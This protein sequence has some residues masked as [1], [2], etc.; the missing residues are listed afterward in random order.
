MKKL[1]LIALAVC[2][3]VSLCACGQ[4]GE[5]SLLYLYLD[6][7]LSEHEAKSLGSQINHIEGVYSSTYISGQEALD[8][9]LEAHESELNI[10]L[11][12]ISMRN[13]FFVIVDT[14]DLDGVIQQ[15]EAI[16][17][18]DQVVSDVQTGIAQVIRS[19]IESLLNI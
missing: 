2:L 18:V 7:N 6:G 17:G 12:D 16:E 13:S 19:W 9:F 14:A 3:L 5:Q 1:I 8:A 15:L 4:Q 11:D 10:P